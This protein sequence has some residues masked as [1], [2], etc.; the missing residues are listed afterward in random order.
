MSEQTSE[1]IKIWTRNPN[2]KY[3]GCLQNSGKKMNHKKQNT[4]CSRHNFFL[5][6]Y[7]KRCAM[8][9]FVEFGVIQP[10]IFWDTGMSSIPNSGPFGKSQV[11]ARVWSGIIRQKFERGCFQCGTRIWM[12]Q[13]SLKDVNC[14]LEHRPDLKVKPSY[15]LSLFAFW[16]LGVLE[17]TVLCSI[18][19]VISLFVSIC[20]HFFHSIPSGLTKC[21]PLHSLDRRKRVRVF[22]VLLMCPVV[23]CSVFVLVGRWASCLPSNFGISVE[24][25]IQWLTSNHIQNLDLQLKALDPGKGYSVTCGFWLPMAQMR[26]MRTMAMTARKKDSA[27]LNLRIL[28]VLLMSRQVRA[29]HYITTSDLIRNPEYVAWRKLVLNRSDGAYISVMSIDTRTF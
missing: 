21:P 25:R 11:F 16:R 19:C 2:W 22:E 10:Q 24:R 18:C 28:F 13:I 7:W 20:S 27:R 14:P 5:F 29:R 26:L 3:D 17:V 15:H 1:I 23:L 12:G 9:L 6:F 8:V 4:S